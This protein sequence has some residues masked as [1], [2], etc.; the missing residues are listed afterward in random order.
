MSV[1]VRRGVAAIVLA[2][3]LPATAPWVHAVPPTAAGEATGTYEADVPA[4]GELCRRN[5]MSTLAVTS[6]PASLG[7]LTASGAGTSNTSCESA[8]FGGGRIVLDVQFATATGEAWECENLAG[9][10]TRT[11]SAVVVIVTGRCTTASTA[12][13]QFT[14]EL[15]LHPI[16]ATSHGWVVGTYTVTGG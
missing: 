8:T 3:A 4:F 10:Y 7:T 9:S 2:A 14:V 16:P 15:T 1:G 6:E 12:T 13:G 5:V 11:A